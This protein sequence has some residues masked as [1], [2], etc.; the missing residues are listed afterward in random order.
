MPYKTF[1][2]WLFDRDQKSEI[3]KPK[4]DKD[5]KV[6]IPDILKYNSPI[7]PEYLLTMFMKNPP[8]NRFLN[9]YL[10]N[11][12]IR[13]LDKRDLFK[14]IKKCVYDFKL[15]RSDIVYIPRYKHDGE[16]FKVLRG[17][18]KILKNHD[19]NL[20]CNIIERSKERDDLYRSFGLK[21]LK[22]QKLK[23]VKKNSRR[24]KISYNELIVRFFN[25]EK[26]GQSKYTKD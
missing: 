6:I 11:M 3:P 1:Q 25:Y 2:N 5:G 24:E 7:T 20:L 13:Y 23:M 4:F 15:K 18:I 12:G 26:K 16:L 21:K 17:N 9:I 19:I 10:N 22:K 14:F 8:M